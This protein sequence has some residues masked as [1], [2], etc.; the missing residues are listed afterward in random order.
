MKQ[1]YKNEIFFSAVSFE[2]FIESIDLPHLPKNISDAVKD[3]RSYLD[4]E[5][6]L[7]S[8]QNCLDVIN[9]AGLPD[10]VLVGNVYMCPAEGGAYSHSRCKYFGMYRLKKVEKIA[11]IRA[12][13]DVEAFSQSKLSW[14]NVNEKTH[15]LLTEAQDKVATFRPSEYPTRIFLL[16]K[17]YDI[18]FIKDTSGGMIGSKQYFNISKLDAKNAASLAKLLKGRNWSEF[19]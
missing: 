12:V 10:D 14:K 15:R 7:P 4:E 18:E 11:L 3:L 17:L 9:C 5:E 6:L 13:V 2:D 1:K 16:D 19:N 8:W